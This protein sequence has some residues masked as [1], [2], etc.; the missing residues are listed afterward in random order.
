[1]MTPA[2]TK[3]AGTAALA[4]LLMLAGASSSV[5]QVQTAMDADNGYPP[6][7]CA[8][9]GVSSDQQDVYCEG[10]RIIRKGW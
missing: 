1:M 5:A 6:R 9:S 10:W 4:G 2:A 3:I 8:P 7:Y